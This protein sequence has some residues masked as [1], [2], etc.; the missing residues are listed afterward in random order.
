MI[1]TVLLVLHTIRVFFLSKL[2]QPI[3][4]QLY[5]PHSSHHSKDSNE[6]VISY[7]VMA[8]IQPHS[9]FKFGKDSYLLKYQGLRNLEY[10]DRDDVTLYSIT[11][12]EFLFVRTRPGVDIYNVE[13]Y[14]FLYAIQHSTAVELLGI[15]HNSVFKYLRSK[16]ARDAGNHGNH[17]SNHGNRGSNRGG[18]HGNQDGSNIRYLYNTGRCGS[19]LAA[20]M[21]F[22]T[23]QVVVLSEPTSIIGLARLLNEKNTT[24]FRKSVEYLELI[25]ATL[26]LTCPDPDLTYLIKPW[27]IHT[28]S[29]MPLIHQTL[30]GVKELFMYRSIRPTL[31]SFKKI[32]HRDLNN[33]AETGVLMLPTKYQAMWRKLKRGTGE[34]ALFF[35]VIVQ[36]YAYK[37]ET[38][39]R[40]NIRSFT[41]EEL[42]KNKKKF[43]LKLLK[44]VG[45]GEEYLQAA[46]SALEKD[47][48]ANSDNLSRKSLSH[49]RTLTISQEVM[50]WAK[51]VAW[52]QFGIKL[53]GVEGLVVNFQ[54]P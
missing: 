49:L 50:D 37:S 27:G 9:A 30:P 44:E 35:T 2:V 19:T 43:T 51:K 48:Q 53:K 25:R 26:L 38:R 32:F 4:N 15:S 5:R 33:I 39:D 52:D 10:L 29:L 12:T 3:L 28:V 11:E 24:L 42:S 13:K 45:V 23:N 40:D 17:D 31:L 34:E 1:E 54:N 16:S 14:P 6:N 7:A 8:D 36:I 47:S 22:K 18:N 46:L 21:I 41:Y 20:A